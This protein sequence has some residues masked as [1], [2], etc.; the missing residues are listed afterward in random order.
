MANARRG[1]LTALAAL[2]GS[3]IPVSA[4][5][6]PVPDTVSFAVKGDWGAGTPAQAAVTR[7][8]CREHALS[9]FAFVLTTGDNFY[10]PDGVATSRNFRVPERCLVQAGVP[11]RAAWGNHDVRGDSTAT[12]LGAS[13]R[14]YAFADGP[15]RVIVLDANRPAEPGQL[16]FLRTALAA[17]REPALVVAFHQPVYTAGLHAPSATARRLWAPLFRRYR[18]SLVLQGHNHHY[19]RIVQGGVTYLTTGGGGQS[20]YP[21]VRPAAGLL[22]CVPAYHFLRVTASRHRLDVRAIE[23]SGATLAVFHLPLTPRGGTG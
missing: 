9:P 3:I 17:A 10:G 20:L 2:A 23:P 13:S 6:A 19:E 7:R 18:V 4:L 16:R 1:L 21:C 11:W 8:M 15:L 5:P 12:V 22:R 14:Y